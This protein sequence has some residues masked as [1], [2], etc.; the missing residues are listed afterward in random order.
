[1]HVEPSL[2]AAHLDPDLRPRVRHEIDVCLVP[3][4]RLTPQAGPGPLGMRDVLHRVV[5]PFL[6]LGAPTS[7]PRSAP[8]P[9]S[10]ACPSLAVI[11]LLAS[12]WV[13]LLLPL[14]RAGPQRNGD[15]Q[16][17]AEEVSQ[18]MLTQTLRDLARHGLITR[19]D[20]H[21]VPP[22][23]EYSLT[24]ARILPCK[25]DRGARRLGNPPLRR[26]STGN[27]Q[28]WMKTACVHSTGDEHWSAR[29]P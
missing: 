4:R 27:S 14:L 13:L 6:V 18:K 26:D 15:H 5:A 25:G 7:P 28:E 17:G 19:H 16:R 12:K 21:E 8:N 20:H 3:G 10:A 11:D 29:G 9:W 22:R 2:R 1:M 24:R 23:V